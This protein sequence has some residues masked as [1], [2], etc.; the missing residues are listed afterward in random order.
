[1]NATFSFPPKPSQASSLESLWLH[2]GAWRLSPFV[3]DVLRDARRLY[4]RPTERGDAP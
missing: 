4:P 2:D 1:M 3:Q